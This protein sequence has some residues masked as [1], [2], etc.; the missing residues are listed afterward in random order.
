MAVVWTFLTGK[1]RL[2][3]L[4]TLISTVLILTGW[5]VLLLK[6]VTPNSKPSANKVLFSPITDRTRLIERLQREIHALDSAINL[7]GKILK[8]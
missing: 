5:M 4:P 7:I 3:L 8:S 1:L 2:V 6:P